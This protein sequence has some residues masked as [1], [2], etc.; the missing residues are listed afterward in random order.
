[1]STAHL[2]LPPTLDCPSASRVARRGGIK[3]AWTTALALALLLGAQ[4]AEA[5]LQD[6]TIVAKSGD[7]VPGLPPTFTFTDLRSPQINAYGDVFFSGG[8]DGPGV[9]YS[10]GRV[11]I[12]DPTDDS[13]QLIRRWGDPYP[14]ASAPPSGGGKIVLTE[15]RQVY[16]EVVGATNPDSADEWWTW[17]PSTGL[18]PFMREGFVTPGGE[19]ITRLDAGGLYGNRG[20]R[21]A[22]VG[23]TSGESLWTR[24]ANGNPEVHF[25]AERIILRPEGASHSGH[26][27]AKIEIP[28]SSGFPAYALE[29]I[30]P[31]ATS[32]R[33]VAFDD[34]LPETGL[35]L[36]NGDVIETAVNSVGDV[37]FLGSSGV[38]A[39]PDK[40]IYFYDGSSLHFIAREDDPALGTSGGTYT[41]SF[42][43]AFRFL[44]MSDWRRAAVFNATV[45][46]PSGEPTEMIVE[47]TA[48]SQRIVAERGDPAPGFAASAML[49]NLRRHITDSFGRVIFHSQ[50]DTDDEALFMDQGP[51][52]PLVALLKTGETLEVA[53]GDVRQISSIAGPAGDQVRFFSISP[54]NVLATEV[55]FDDGTSAVIRAPLPPIATSPA[56]V[57]GLS[58]SM[59]LVLAAVLTSLGWAST[60]ILAARPC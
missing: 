6:V 9:E 52:R 2:D 46:L 49:T 48:T 60:R 31:D 20:Y 54:G 5:A 25:A 1:M 27:A 51:G 39:G 57:P 23:G 32:T 28:S 24:N 53:P 11:L 19:L 45:L 41:E 8:L 44:Q 17:Q 55:E 36:R 12:A 30:N 59:I 42:G 43:T 4:A 47:A 14:G 56:V 15:D 38:F 35:Y 26:V 40:L 33:V 3:S 58:A 16:V 34:S 22:R 7:A 21:V 29:R 18:T 13:M 37:A 50:V 10:N